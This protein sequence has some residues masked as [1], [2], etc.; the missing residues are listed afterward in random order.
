MKAPP[1]LPRPPITITDEREDD[2]LGGER[3]DD[4]ASEGKR[5]SAE[6]GEE[7]ADRE[8][9][10]EQELHVDPG[11]GAEVPGRRRLL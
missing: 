9:A 5:P 11:K 2:E 4:E 10:R 8:D 6:P 3:G 7:A 1:K